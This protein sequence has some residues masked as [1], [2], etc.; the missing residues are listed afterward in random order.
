MTEKRPSQ[1]TS[2]SHEITAVPNAAVS[3]VYGAIS[4]S[5][6]C[7]I[8]SYLWNRKHFKSG[9]DDVRA[10]AKLRARNW[11]KY[12]ALAGAFWFGTETALKQAGVDNEYVTFA[13]LGTGFG[14]IGGVVRRAPAALIIKSSLIMGVGVP[15]VWA[16]FKGATWLYEKFPETRRLPPQPQSSATSNVQLVPPNV[17][18]KRDIDVDVESKEANSKA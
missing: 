12:G 7:G 3:A 16:A 9:D 4:V 17:I 10:A 15:A 11:T 14:V 1:Y 2:H 18:I 6:M 5:A 8:G 13:I